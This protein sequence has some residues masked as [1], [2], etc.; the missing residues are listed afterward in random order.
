MSCARSA[1]LG[2][3]AVLAVTAAPSASASVRIDARGAVVRTAAGAAIVTRTPLRIVFT[4][5]S[6]RVV[7]R[8]APPAGRSL[9]LG[10]PPAP[11]APGY[12]PPLQRTL[13][14]PFE[15]T[16]GSEA[17]LVRGSGTWSGDLL[18]TVRTGSVFSARR[19]LSL[20]RA[21]AGLRLELSTSDPSGRRLIVTIGPGP[22]AALVLSARPTPGGRCRNR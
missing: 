17:D 15:F 13:Y 7:L 16:V 14:G 10:A 6:G 8:Q 20:T 5:P 12:G 3:V 4:D 9:R 18:S 11:S 21:G 22:G 1:T 2:V 19:V